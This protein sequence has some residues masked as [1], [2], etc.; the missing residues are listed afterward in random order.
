MTRFLSSDGF[1]NRGLTT[2]RE[3]ERKGEKETKR[4]REGREGGGE[5]ESERKGQDSYPGPFDHKSD[6]LTTELSPLSSIAW[7]KEAWKE[8]VVHAVLDCVK[9]VLKW[10]N[11][12][13]RT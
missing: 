9:P 1:F 8:T 5:R 10:A 12:C 13:S 7:R 2:A 6:A 4:E 11:V 3:S